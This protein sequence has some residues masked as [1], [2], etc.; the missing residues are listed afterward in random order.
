ML[1]AF[2]AGGRADAGRGRLTLLRFLAAPVGV[3]AIYAVGASWLTYGFLAGDWARSWQLGVEPFLVVDAAKSVIA[4]LAAEGARAAI[5]R[6]R[7]P[8][9]R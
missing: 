2:L 7:P 1:G 6:T 5:E 9:A 3:A 4:A 8:A